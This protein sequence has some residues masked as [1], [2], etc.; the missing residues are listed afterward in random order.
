MTKSTKHDD[1]AR[2]FDAFAQRNN[3]LSVMGLPL[4]EREVRA[5]FG[6]LEARITELEASKNTGC[7]DCDSGEF[8]YVHNGGRRR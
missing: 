1:L 5:L 4:L 2:L 3:H 8:C 7:D 6:K